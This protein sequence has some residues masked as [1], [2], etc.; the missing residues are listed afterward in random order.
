MAWRHGWDGPRPYA[1]G[2]PAWR[3][4]DELAMLQDQAAHVEAMLEDIQNRIADI[5]KNKKG[6]E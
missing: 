1:Y 6:K 2:P 5:E 3:S 4:E